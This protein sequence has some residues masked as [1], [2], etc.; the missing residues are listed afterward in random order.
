LALV[1]TLETHD[2]PLSPDEEGHIRHQLEVLGKRLDHF[3]EPLATVVLK[4]HEL[5]REV[6]VA[7]RVEPG[8]LGRHLI[9]HQ[10][11]ETAPH[12]VRLAVEDVERELERLLSNERGEQT[13]GVPSRRLRQAGRPHPPEPSLSGESLKPLE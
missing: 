5:Q 10:A 12:A 3:P 9:S 6:E 4:R 1:I 2:C 13:Y 11:A 7:L 8:P